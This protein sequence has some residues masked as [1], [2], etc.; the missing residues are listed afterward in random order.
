MPKR[1]KKSKTK[2]KFVDPRTLWVQGSELEVLS[3][4]STNWFRGKI[5]KIFNDNEGEWLQITWNDPAKGVMAREVQRYSDQIEPINEDN[6]DNDN[7]NDSNDVSPKKAEVKEEPKIEVLYPVNNVNMGLEIDYC[8]QCE[9]PYEYCKYKPDLSDINL[10]LKYISKKY[11]A[12]YSSSYENDEKVKKA[13]K[14]IEALK[15]RERKEQE[16]QE[17]K[18]LE[19]IN[20]ANNNDSNYDN[21]GPNKGNYK[22]NKGGYKSKRGGRI[23]RQDLLQVTNNN[24]NRSTE[25]VKAKNSDDSSSEDELLEANRN[26]RGGGKKAYFKQRKKQRKDERNQERNKRTK[27]KNKQILDEDELVAQR[28]KKS[29]NN[30]NNDGESKVDKMSPIQEENS[31]DTKPTVISKK[32][33]KG[34]KKKIITVAY[35]KVK[36]NKRATMVRGMIELGMKPKVAQSAFRKKFATGVGCNPT[37]DGSKEFVLQGDL[38]YDIMKFMDIKWKVPHKLLFYESK[39]GLIPAFNDNGICMPPP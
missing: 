3:P 30:A 32:D 36:G 1:K 19:T 35:K 33:K 6:N 12:L 8:R 22:R 17:Q 7:N 25:A 11:P 27:N 4:G 21:S 37:P 34:K 23:E 14:K 18:N 9:L 13:L 15:E 20:N 10:C 28:N 26:Q 16:L 38:R 31:N 39:K 29:N 24:K 5:T 2:Q